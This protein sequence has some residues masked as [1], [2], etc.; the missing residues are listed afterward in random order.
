MLI[1]L[2]LSRNLK[3]RRHFSRC[4]AFIILFLTLISSFAVEVNA[5]SND[6]RKTYIQ[7][8]QGKSL[9]DIS[10]IKN[11]DRDSLRAISLYLSN[12]YTPFSTVLDKD[13]EKEDN[14]FREYMEKALSQYC[15][16]QKDAAKLLVEYAIQESLGTCQKVYMRKQD[17][18]S[19]MFL[20]G[21]YLGTIPKELC[22]GYLSNEAGG[23]P[24]SS[25]FVQ[26]TENGNK[27]VSGLVG[28]KTAGK[29]YNAGKSGNTFYP[30]NAFY[31][32]TK[33][34]LDLFNGG[35]NI[36]K[37]DSHGNKVQFVPVTYATFLSTMRVGGNFLNIELTPKAD[38]NKEVNFIEWY[39]GD[40]VKIDG[41]LPF[42]KY[43]WHTSSE[44]KYVINFYWLDATT[45]TMK[46]CF[47]NS[48]ECLETYC[49]LASHLN[50]KEGI[51]S[52]F[53]AFEASQLKSIVNTSAENAGKSTIYGQGLY[54]NW[55]GDLVLDAGDWR[56]IVLPGCTNP[57]AITN[58]AGNVDSVNMVNVYSLASMGNGKI[59]MLTENPT[60]FDLDYDT[61][62]ED[63]KKIADAQKRD[64]YMMRTYVGGGS[65]IN[66]N[67]YRLNYN[68]SSYDFDDNKALFNK[69]WGSGEAF[70][71]ALKT[72]KGAGFDCTGS[73]DYILFPQFNLVS[74]QYALSVQRDDDDN[75]TAKYTWGIS[76]KNDNTVEPS[77]VCGDNVLINTENGTDALDILFKDYFY[78]PYS[79][80]VTD[81]GVFDTDFKDADEDGDGVA[82]NAVYVDENDNIRADLPLYTVDSD[83][84]L[85]DKNDS[86]SYI[87][88]CMHTGK[89]ASLT[90]VRNARLAINRLLDKS[91]L[92]DNKNNTW[93]VKAGA[94]T[95]DLKLI[96][97]V[98]GETY[99]NE[100]G[101]TTS[102]DYSFSFAQ[103]V[104][105]M[106]CNDVLLQY[107]N[108]SGFSDS[109]NLTDFFKVS[110]IKG[111]YDQY[112]KSLC[113]TVQFSKVSKYSSQISY[114]ASL[115][116]FFQP[117]FLTYCFAY[118][119]ADSNTDTFDKESH[120]VNLKF[121]KEN[122]P[123]A[124][125]TDALDFSSIEADAMQNEVMGMLYY[126]LHPVEGI[127]YVATWFINKIG[128]L[129]LR[130]HEDMVGS[131]DSNATTGMTKYLGFEGYTTMPSLYDVEFVAN[132]LN[133]YDNLMV[134]LIIL[135]AVILLCYV[136]VGQ[137][138][139]TRG[140][141]GVFM[142]ALLAFLPP[143]AIT[144]TANLVN[145]SCDR[146]YSTKFDFW[147]LCQLQQYLGLLNDA[148]DTK[149]ITDYA[150]ILL[151]TKTNSEESVAGESRTSYSGV[152][153]KWISPKKFNSI[154]DLSEQFNNSV[155][156]DAN[157]LKRFMLNSI[158]SSSSGETYLDTDNA[159]YL[160]RDYC[161]IYRYASVSYNL[162]TTFN[163]NKLF[164]NRI[165]FTSV[166]NGVTPATL[167][168]YYAIA[169][170]GDSST[171]YLHS[172]WTDSNLTL[173]D[174]TYSNCYTWIERQG[175]QTL[176][177]APT[178]TK[179]PER[180][181]LVLT[182]N[183]AREGQTKNLTGAILA[184]QRSYTL[185]DSTLSGKAKTIIQ[186]YKDV[187]AYE[188]VV[189]GFQIDT[190]KYYDADGVA[191]SNAEKLNYFNRDNLASSLAVNY[192]SVY[193]TMH[194]N[195][196]RLLN[197]EKK[198]N[199]KLS[200][201][202]LAEGKFLYGLD[203]MNFKDG[204]QQFIGFKDV[205]D[206][207]TNLEYY[208][209]LSYYY[210]GL[211]SESPFYF[212]S[213]N[214]QDQ[215]RALNTG[216]TYNFDDLSSS[217]ATGA[218][219]EMF[220]SDNQKYFFN[221]RSNSEAGYGELR[222]FMNMHDLF[223]YIIPLMDTGVS[224]VDR[225]DDRFGMFT[226]DS[227][228]L[229]F[230]S[231]GT[232]SYG[233]ADSTYSSFDE[234]KDTYSNLNEQEKYEF[235]HDYNVNQIFN[236]YSSWLDT[237]E[238]CQY[239]KPETIN[240]LGEKFTVLNP[241]DP[242]SYYNIDAD[243]KM[244]GRYMVFSESEMKYYGLIESDLTA[245]ERKILEVQRNVYNKSIDLMNYY[246]LN[247][248]VLIQAYSMIQLFEF[249]K[250][251][252]QNSFIYDDYTL[253][254]QGYEL[255]AFTYDAYLRLII[256]ESSGDKLM[257]SSEDGNE[258]I[259]K[260]VLNKTSI[261][262]AVILIVNDVV[263]VYLIPLLKL[264]F[265]LAIFFL[266]IAFIVSAAVKMELDIVNVTV[267]CLLVPL[268][269]FALVS[270][271]MAWIVSL[272]MSNGA[273]GVVKTSTTISL[274]DPT[275]V[276]ILM[277]LINIVALIFYWKI[278]KNTFKNLITYVKAV[279]TNIAGAVAG[280]LGV[281]SRIAKGDNSK[282]IRVN[283]V[284]GTS[285]SRGRQ[286]GSGFAKGVVAGGVGGAVAG[287]MMSQ[288]TGATG[289]G[290][291][292][293]S[294]VN[295][296]D[297]LMGAN[298][299]RDSVGVDQDR[300]KINK[301]NSLM[302]D[303]QAREA[304]KEAKFRRSMSG[305]YETA[306]E[307]YS[308][309]KSSYADARGIMKD[310]NASLG[311]RIGAGGAALKYKYRQVRAGLGVVGTG[312]ASAPKRGIKAVGRGVDSATG[313]RVSRLVS[314]A[315]NYELNKAQAEAMPAVNRLRNMERKEADIRSKVL[316]EREQQRFNKLADNYFQSSSST[317]TV[318]N[319]RKKPRG[320][321]R[322]YRR[323]TLEEARRK[324]GSTK[325]SQSNGRGKKKGKKKGK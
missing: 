36:S 187:S 323:R 150:S 242:T 10:D 297:K 2:K 278:C 44:N 247:D 303:K 199:L 292:R 182:N 316:D 215:L 168:N 25:M 105:P 129:L 209:R 253:Y 281:V 299:G 48:E 41:K 300:E 315:K 226:Y 162:Y 128:G 213:F 16:F 212:F 246:T 178:V 172:R 119:N 202:N 165:P 180:S 286:N 310:K 312:I 21:G 293:F 76:V 130:I 8:A 17:L 65:L 42:E 224:L 154:A 46:I 124:S 205:K 153:V 284:G 313:N 109:G 9:T 166:V 104:S 290:D 279:F 98:I 49:M 84:A 234:F 237:M 58:I 51:G 34:L 75:I 142:F 5:D 147:A 176:A 82:D 141:I 131:T 208:D 18:A 101:D 39:Y 14:D 32:Y 222:D 280:A 305:K 183:K 244:T 43:A 81:Y 118:F 19:V 70:I 160:Y 318:V 266:S 126:F 196:M 120:L 135:I 254:P 106:W 287:S 158:S 132:I 231:D 204:I 207:E 197:D 90:D 274:G 64:K 273:D 155:E 13:Y 276:V 225:F 282:S 269:C 114:D 138:T 311:T 140:I 291:S 186:T 91:M 255:K 30:T 122:F 72:I 96:G 151:Q 74:T 1:L 37:K 270:V 47:S 306:K 230:N 87:L 161:D 218:I 108:L 112:A 80:L 79:L 185:D 133:M 134:Y 33:Y 50:Y 233:G 15:G 164:L 240:V 69:T 103:F 307:K 256:S 221:Y 136:L 219:K 298:K 325:S 68:S 236:C 61:F 123:I 38:K 191:T 179:K 22:W 167:N 175:N 163:F 67:Y 12:F 20:N 302:E 174:I 95:E 216:Y 200:A 157:Y 198:K 235:W 85:V 3:L 294:E 184:N 111:T 194:Q 99:D 277:M 275:M 324:A 249:N 232:F 63:Q 4:L 144:A 295:K 97:K 127:Q 257:T 117:L 214:V 195:Y 285:E 283:T 268:C 52:G 210:Y 56:Y 206:V 241:L 100:K 6:L 321:N 62:S 83:D 71:N 203:S 296:Y 223:Y 113:N 29:R 107:D 169:V 258:S 272:F 26:D 201:D 45:D 149:D 238:D 146:I 227:C 189:K 248:E 7:L 152:K 190:M 288:P 102:K 60:G 89:N 188:G 40:S 229:R 145:T 143:V 309:A 181:G 73:S 78:S 59:E 245:V 24:V 116:A 211:Y 308:D 148:Q 171:D 66:L 137:L 53:S 267:K 28:E 170:N 320:E 263:A 243:G 319:S 239:A 77:F 193:D 35:K 31:Q 54:V 251:F 139:L 264:F 259:Y 92:I 93:T 265:L 173:K 271:G 289:D 57:Y 86:W 110:R 317:V 301:Y 11:I 314:D 228:P 23:I 192:N 177:N 88:P 304:Q 121:N 217:T 159:L 262:F 125:S 115:K 27:S 252:S 220:L 94:S 261:L 55:V 322:R 260:R 250:A 156:T